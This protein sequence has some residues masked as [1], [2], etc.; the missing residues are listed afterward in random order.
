ME[1]YF[2]LGPI[3]WLTV[4]GLLTLLGGTFRT[5][6][7]YLPTI[8]AIFAW[9]GVGIGVY[10]AWA[11]PIPKSSFFGVIWG[12]GVYSFLAAAIA[13]VGALGLSFVGAY[14]ARQPEYQG[15]EALPLLLLLIGV[16]TV[17]PA[18]NHLLLAIVVLETVSLGAYVLVG[19]AWKNAPAAE[20]A[21]KYFLLGAV[22]FAFLLFGVSYLYGLTATLY[23]HHLWPMRWEGWYGH[24]L[25][26]VAMGMLGIGL[27]F[28]LSVFPFHWWAPDVY[29]GATP[30]AAGVVVAL[31][32]LSAAFLAGLL[33]H[34]IAVP[35]NWLYALA[36]IAAASSIF[37]NLLALRQTSLQ[38][39]LGYSSVAHGGYILLALVSGP[40]GRLQAWA[41]AVVYGLMSVLAFGLLALREEP[42]EY[43]NLRGLGY[44]RPGYGLALALALGS[45]SG[46]PPLVGFFAKYAVFVA[47]FRAGYGLPAILALIGALIGYYAY[48]RPISW[49]YQPGE[50]PPVFRPALALGAILLLGI[51]V[52]PLLLWGAMDYLYGLAGFFLPRP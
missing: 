24:P 29:G 45:L 14:I 22:G 49:L 52:L 18:S 2:G 7:R 42:L 27:L 8:S 32:K 16:L 6:R 11:Y 48:W 26:A 43:K 9:F 35:Q 36:G 23:F 38:R 5:F 34:Y 1:S 19:L 46:I 40:E 39:M 50:A 47:A 33:L 44:A 17:L 20:A 21:V 4:G 15:W 25:F 28:K 30:A 13:L 3:G 41:Y 12:G 37:G 10:L 51:G 31:G